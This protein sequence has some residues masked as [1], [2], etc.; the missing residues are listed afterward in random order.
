M[1]YD[2]V[3][4][5]LLVNGLDSVSVI[6]VDTIVVALTLASTLG[7]WRVY[8]RSAWISLSLTKLLAASQRLSCK[9]F[10]HTDNNDRSREI[11]VGIMAKLFY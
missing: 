10:L 8:K 4:S 2:V 3:D 1:D 11:G 5:Y 6:V 7:T 9:I